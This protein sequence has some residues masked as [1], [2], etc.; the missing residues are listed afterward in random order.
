MIIPNAAKQAN[1]TNGNARRLILNTPTNMEAIPA[2][3][4][5]ITE[6]IDNYIETP[7]LV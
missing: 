1:N 6:V 5:T 7:I 4:N 2:A 3:A